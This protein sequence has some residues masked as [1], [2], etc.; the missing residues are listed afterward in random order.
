MSKNEIGERLRALREEAGQTKRFLAK[1]VDC[2]YTSICAYEYGDRVPS[3]RMKIRLA[4][5]FHKTVGEI[6]FPDENHETRT[7]HDEVR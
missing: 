6:F 4:E 2:S 5:H 7:D 3:D 1:A